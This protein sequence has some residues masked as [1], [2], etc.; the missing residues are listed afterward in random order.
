M[1]SWEIEQWAFQQE[2]WSVKAGRGG[3]KSMTWLVKVLPVQEDETYGVLQ[4]G[5]WQLLLLLLEG[6]AL[7]LRLLQAKELRM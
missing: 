1:D 3:L 6:Q 4:H 7:V 5:Q 2:A